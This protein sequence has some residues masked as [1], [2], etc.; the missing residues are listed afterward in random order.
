[1]SDDLLR[2]ACGRLFDGV[3]PA[4]RE[5]IVVTTRAGRIEEIAAGDAADA[6][7]QRARGDAGWLDLTG[8]TVL[9]GLIDCHD[10]VG[11]DLG[12]IGEQVAEGDVSLTLR[13]VR[14]CSAALDAGIT[15]LRDMGEHADLAVKWRDAVRSGG[16]R[17]P[18]LIVAGTWI[19]RTG[20]HVWMA[21]READGP[22]E[23]ARAIREQARAGSDWIKL[24]ITGGITTPGSD[25][26][27][28]GYTREEINAAV[29][30]AHLVGLPVTAHIH[31]GTGLRD[32]ILAGID[33]V[34][35][36]TFGTREDLELMSEH[37]VAL[38]S[39][40]GVLDVGASDPRLSTEVRDKFRRA[41]EQCLDAL[42]IAR[43]VGL[44]VAVGTD[45]NHADIAREL[46]GLAA[47]GFTPMEALTAA[48]AAAGRVLRRDDLGVLRPG[49]QADL[50]AVRGGLDGLDAL[51]DILLVMQG[52]VV[53]RDARPERTA[54]A[55]AE[56]R[57]T[58]TL[59]PRSGPEPEPEGML[60]TIG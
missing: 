37:G 29:N 11:F 1:M 12:D 4:F 26:V 58:G 19:T 10:H 24:V 18:R 5:S 8:H 16:L 35:H 49:A 25:P 42:A 32:A 17:G 40:F 38:V 48:T 23:I 53:V 14:T 15:T 50:I 44:T 22:H 13:A 6:L 20:G 7:R 59:R 46:T 51:E 33:C 39:T 30:E 36:A 56:G 55:I 21:G 57:P 9:P 52:G 3:E 28:R 31:G 27:A 2:I 41:R 47:A 34:E 43:D 54:A 60:G 45:L